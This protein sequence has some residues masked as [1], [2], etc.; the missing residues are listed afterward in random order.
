MSHERFDKIISRMQTE[1]RVLWVLVGSETNV[2][3]LLRRANAKL[4]GLYFNYG[5]DHMRHDAKILVVAQGCSLTDIPI[6][7]DQSLIYRS[8]QEVD[9]TN[10][11]FARFKSAGLTVHIVSVQ[12]PTDG[13]ID[14]LRPI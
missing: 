7:Q 8:Y 3:S 10:P 11:E 6:P 12:S 13:E 14:P 1:E 5:V 2:T 9:E 4:D